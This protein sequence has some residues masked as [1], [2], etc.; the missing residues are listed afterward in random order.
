M[1]LAVMF[2]RNV[3]AL[4]AGPRV[5]RIRRQTTTLQLAPAASPVDRRGH[6]L[7][8]MA[9]RFLNAAFSMHYR[10]PPDNRKG[11]FNKPGS[12]QVL[13]KD[14]TLDIPDS[15]N[16]IQYTTLDKDAWHNLEGGC[17]D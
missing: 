4:T 9:I 7:K 13:S 8:H 15:M 5:R 12:R 10:G 11:I 14:D 16:K 3:M 2:P 1:I 6:G 17:G